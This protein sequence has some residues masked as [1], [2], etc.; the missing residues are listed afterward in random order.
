MLCPEV[1]QREF[2][3]YKP[4]EQLFDERGIRFVLLLNLE[5]ICVDQLGSF[6]AELASFSVAVG[7]MLCKLL[8]ICG[9]VAKLLLGF[10]LPF[11]LENIY[12]ESI[13]QYFE[14]NNAFSTKL[15]CNLLCKMHIICG[16][17]RIICNRSVQYW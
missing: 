13:N 4:L 17:S 10:M 11:S 6:T 2:K 8:S 14:Q 1:V 3:S 12:E 9:T 15:T 16:Y 5:L 7:V